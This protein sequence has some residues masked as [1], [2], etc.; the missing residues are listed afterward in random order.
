MTKNKAIFIHTLWRTSSTWW[1]AQFRNNPAF[2]SFY[3]PFHENLLTRTH[4]QCVHSHT[5]KP[6]AQIFRHPEM[7]EHY[8]REFPLREGGGVDGFEERF[9]LD[10]FIRM[11]GCDDKAM[12]TYVQSLL[13][14]AEQNNK[15][16]VF[17]LSRSALRGG[18]MKN[19]FGGIHAY[20]V[21]EPAA[22]F[23]SSLSFTRKDALSG[24][25]GNYFLACPVMIVS[26]NSGDPLFRGMAG[27]FGLK[28]FQASTFSEEI[29]HFGKVTESLNVQAHRDISAFLWTIG[30][31]HA[32]RYADLVI[33]A[34]L[35][36]SVA[37]RDK[38]ASD[39]SQET[40]ARISFEDNYHLPS[41]RSSFEVSKPV[42]TRI[43]EACQLLQPDWSR[44]L[45]DG[46]L[47]GKSN[48]ALN[49]IIPGVRACRQ[50]LRNPRSAYESKPSGC[51]S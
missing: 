12:A 15:V 31:A 20:L 32:S 11:P 1:W 18:W 6:K 49:D 38:I 35:A 43:I 24:G 46:T 42:K 3:E 13:N 28:P 5:S 27:H 19:I 45:T 30:L 34:D 37:Y 14:C 7:Q 47:S 41:G 26:Q 48:E 29:R 4:A 33:D 36:H 10:S 50:F 44:L 2:M 21:R 51:G 17:K 8:F 16:A 22:M 39:L 40:G 25:P 9:A 23:E